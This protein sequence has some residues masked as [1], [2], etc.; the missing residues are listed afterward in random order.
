MSRDN[1]VSRRSAVKTGLAIL[2]AGM[3]AAPARAQPP[4]DDSEP[5]LPK[6]RVHYQY[7]PNAQGSHCSICA[8]FIV[9]SSC[10]IVE[11]TISPGGYCL[12]FSPKDIDLNK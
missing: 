8:N 1:K 12:V 2:A 4:D 5:K 10:H 11:G 3:A 7:T 6:S 9:P